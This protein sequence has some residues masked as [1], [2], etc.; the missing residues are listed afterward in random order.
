VKW[1]PT[2]TYPRQQLSN[3]AGRDVLNDYEYNP[4]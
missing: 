4:N 3:V 1:P 2:Q